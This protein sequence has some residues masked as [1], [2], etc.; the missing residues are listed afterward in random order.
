[1]KDDKFE[2]PKANVNVMIYAKT[3]ME[4]YGSI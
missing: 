2:H 1:M 3:D 4:P